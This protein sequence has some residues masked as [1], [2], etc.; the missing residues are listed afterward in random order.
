MDRRLLMGHARGDVHDQYGS[1]D[2]SRS[3][4]ELF[5]ALSFAYVDLSHVCDDPRRTKAEPA[6]EATKPETS[7]AKPEPLIRFAEIDRREGYKYRRLPRAA[8][9][10]R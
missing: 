4:P 5:A 3:L 9:K 2:L 8:T 10:G 7:Q 1:G 6:S